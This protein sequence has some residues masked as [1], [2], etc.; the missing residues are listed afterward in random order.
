M[1]SVLNDLENA[2]SRIFL[3]GFDINGLSL[4]RTQIDGA[5][6]EGTFAA[7]T[8]YFAK[9]YSAAGFP[10]LL[11]VDNFSFQLAPI[12]ECPDSI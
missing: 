5:G 8:I 11:G 9:I 7:P 10:G 1:V 6:T 4:G 2:P 12:D 3:E